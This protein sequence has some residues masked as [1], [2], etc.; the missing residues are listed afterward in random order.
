MKYIDYKFKNILAIL[1]CILFVWI[2]YYWIDQ[3]IV[4]YS[5]AHQ[6]YQY[7]VFLWLTYIP[8]IL[9]IL[10]FIYYL[11]FAIRFGLQIIN[12]RDK[13]YLAMANSLVIATFIKNQLKFIFGR[14]WPKTWENNNP[15]LIHNHAYG[16]HFWHFGKAYESF[17]S[18]HMAITVAVM[19]VIWQIY[20]RLRGFAVLISILVAVGLA[21]MNFHFV[22]DMVAGSF[23]GALTAS[24]VVRYSHSKS[25]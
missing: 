16:F 24:L 13:V 5:E 11:I 17:P 23:V 7:K 25:H 22:T 1:F 9:V 3:P 4:F 2:G 15:S 8:N 21:G 6:F 20:P 14:Y 12:K 19:A 10:A 18:G